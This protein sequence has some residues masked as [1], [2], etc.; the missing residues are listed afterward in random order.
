MLEHFHD[1]H[2][3]KTYMFQNLKYLNILISKRI[4]VIMILLIVKDIRLC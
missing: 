1:Y 2:Q 3:I 4:K